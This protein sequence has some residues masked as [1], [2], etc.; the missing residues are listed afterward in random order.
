VAEITA[1]F[2]G[3]FPA[4]LNITVLV[5]MASGL[6]M[7]SRIMKFVVL[8]RDALRAGDNAVIGR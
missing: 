1:R 2:F 8:G 6:L 4:R 3:H 7:V 5:G